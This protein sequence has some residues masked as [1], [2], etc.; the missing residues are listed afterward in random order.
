MRVR[1]AGGR[2]D[3]AV[4]RQEHG[5]RRRV[6]HQRAEPRDLVAGDLPTA[7]F[8]QVADTEHE[9]V[10]ERRRRSSRRVASR[11]QLRTR[12][13]SERADL[14]VLHAREGERGELEVVGV[15]EVEPVLADRLV[16]RDPEEPLGGAVG[17]PDVGAGVD[18][19]HGVG[20]RLRDG[21]QGR[22]A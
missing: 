3:D 1:P 7:A 21:G 14:L 8:G 10:A 13:S 12:S 19:E 4:A 22:D 16:D 6:L 15:D 20:Q 5:H 18:H 11:P 9:V 2:L 17:P